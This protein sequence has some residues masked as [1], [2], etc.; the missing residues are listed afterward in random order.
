MQKHNILINIVLY[1]PE[2]KQLLDLLRI[3]SHYPR[4]KILLFDNAHLSSLLKSQISTTIVYFQSTKNVGV[5]GAHFFACEMAVKEGFDFI[6]FLDQDTI[7]DTSFIETMLMKFCQLEKIYPRLAAIGPAWIDDRFPA[8]KPRKCIK[9]PTRSRKLIS[10]GM[11]IKVAFLSEIGYP[12]KEYFID[13]VDTEWCLRAINKNYQLIKINE[14]PMRHALGEIRKFACFYLRYHKP[15]RYYYYI[16]NSFFMFRETWIPLSIRLNILIRSVVVPVIKIPLVPQP[17]ASC[18]AV[19]QAIKVGII[20]LW[21]N[22]VV[23]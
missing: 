1:N 5:G 7:L 22:K 19:W 11:L 2:E 8:K 14:V 10:S 15:I 3:C 16:R 13:H 20:H 9:V 6:L 12:K 23:A 21:K 18:N 17:L 4:A